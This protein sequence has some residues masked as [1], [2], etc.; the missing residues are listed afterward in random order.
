MLIWYS[1][2]TKKLQYI[3]STFFYLQYSD[4][5]F[6]SSTYIYNTVIYMKRVFNGTLREFFFSQFYAIYT[7]LVNAIYMQKRIEELRTTSE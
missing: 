6:F 7:R 5:T 2:T 3:D 4:L 1:S